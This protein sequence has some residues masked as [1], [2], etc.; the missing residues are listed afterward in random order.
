MSEIARALEKN[1]GSIHY[2]VSL[3]GG[4][5]PAERRRSRLALSLPEREDTFR[6]WCKQRRT[7]TRPRGQWAHPPRPV[8]GLTPPPDPAEKQK[9]ANKLGR[10]RSVAKTRLYELNL[11]MPPARPL[12]F[13]NWSRRRIERIER[14]CSHQK[15]FFAVVE[16]VS[17]G[18]RS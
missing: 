9:G 1:H 4:I 18:I 11:A 16:A 8:G 3:H 14:I 10:A 13:S 15:D 5:P 17:V 7:L 12:S 2:A 6:H